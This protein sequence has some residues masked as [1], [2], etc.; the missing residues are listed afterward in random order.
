MFLA[1]QISHYQ[2][3]TCSDSF[4]L[5]SFHVEGVT[6]DGLCLKLL[7]FNLYYPAERRKGKGDVSE[8]QQKSLHCK[9]LRTYRHT[10]FIDAFH[11]IIKGET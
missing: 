8:K 10:A 7:R 11:I 5:C 4:S 1:L 9:C 2:V 3:V 6:Y